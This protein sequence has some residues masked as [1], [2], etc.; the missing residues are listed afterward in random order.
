[1]K[2]IEITSPQQLE[3]AY[4]IIKELAPT[5]EKQTFLDSLNHDLLKNHKLFGLTASGK[6][7]SV[8]AVWLLMNGL[9][10]KFLWINAFVTTQR[11]RSKGCGTLLLRE[12]EAYAKKEK[13]DEIRVHTHREKAVAFWETRA[14]FETFSHVLRKKIRY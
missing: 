7:V 2:F 8:A 10:E 13:Y 4:F 14:N 9:F 12:L 3:E 5:L 6:L 1:M 11:M